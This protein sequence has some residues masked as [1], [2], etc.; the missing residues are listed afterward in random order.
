MD[1]HPNA[2]GRC[3]SGKR[4]IR[5]TELWDA[6]VRLGVP[7]ASFYDVNPQLDSAAA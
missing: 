4:N 3:E 5:A 2:L 7:V 1:I 6:A